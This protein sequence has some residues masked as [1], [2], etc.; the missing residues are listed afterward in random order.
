MP[1]PPT[2][3]P[4]LPTVDLAVNPSP[5]A[6]APQQQRDGA[7]ALAREDAHGPVMG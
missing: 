2:C 4:V 7:T 1:R 5:D 3:Y 6:E